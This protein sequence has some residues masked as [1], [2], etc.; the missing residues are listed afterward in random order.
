MDK[1]QKSDKEW[2]EQLSPE[3]YRIC[4]Q[5]GTEPAF[6]GEYWNTKAPGMYHCACCDQPLFDANTKFDS[7]TGWPSFH[8]PQTEDAV[9]EK[10]DRTLWMRRTEVLCSRCDAHL[11]HVFNDGPAPTGLRYCINSAALKH[12]PSGSG[13]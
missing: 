5:H 4:R 3:Q 12:K 10:V 8:S 11:G 1:I 9:A 2:Q 13:G 7:G 6:T